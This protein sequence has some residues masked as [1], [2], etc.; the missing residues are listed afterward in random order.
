MLCCLMVLL[1]VELWS[2]HSVGFPLRALLG[3]CHSSP[4]CCSVRPWECCLNSVSHPEEPAINEAMGVSRTKKTKDSNSRW[5]PWWGLGLYA[6]AAS[7]SGQLIAKVIY[8]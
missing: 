6:V 5:A 1:E 7:P 3:C 8:W 4:S 2:E